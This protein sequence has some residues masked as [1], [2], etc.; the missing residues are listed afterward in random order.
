[1]AFLPS[2]TTSPRRSSRTAGSSRRRRKNDSPARRR[3]LAFRASA[4]QFCLDE[5]KID[6]GDVDYDKAFLKFER[7][8]ETYLASAPR[9]SAREL[10]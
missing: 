9:L 5:A 10:R 2:T 6:L 8:L 1:L 3:I 4:I 7:L